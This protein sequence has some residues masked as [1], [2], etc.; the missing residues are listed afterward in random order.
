MKTANLIAT[1]I[2]GK[3]TNIGKIDCSKDGYQNR[4][5]EIMKKCKIDWVTY[6]IE[7]IY[8]AGGWD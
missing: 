8:K 3:K 6:T 4:A 1:D 5:F 7:P 2:H